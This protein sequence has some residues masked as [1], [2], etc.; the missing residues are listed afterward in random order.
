MC[1]THTA[2]VVRGLEGRHNPVDRCAKYKNGCAMYKIGC[3]K[4]RF[5]W[6][7]YAGKC[8]FTR[9]ANFLL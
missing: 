5:W 6:A 2:H 3:A 7:I 8:A 1:I 4:Y 9:K